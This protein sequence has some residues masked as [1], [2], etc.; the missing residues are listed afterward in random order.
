[1]FSLREMLYQNCL[2]KLKNLCFRWQDS[3]LNVFKYCNKKNLRLHVEFT[4]N[5]SK[6]PYP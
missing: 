4:I 3:V 6:I 5:G 2:L 1:M